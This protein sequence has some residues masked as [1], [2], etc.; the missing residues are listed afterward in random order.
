MRR[1]LAAPAVLHTLTCIAALS[2]SACNSAPFFYDDRC[3]PVSRDVSAAQS[4]PNAAGDSLGQVWITLVESRDPDIQRA[5]WYVSGEFLRGHLESARLVATGDTTL[6]LPL[7]GSP[8]GP[9]L[10]ITGQLDPYTGPVDFNQLFNR[11]THGGLTIVL[12]TSIPDR[13]VV[14]LPLVQ[15]VQ[16][17]DWGRA[18]C[19]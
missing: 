19:S 15:V 3:G 9:D 4:I 10:I 18:P 14:T 6:L 8:S 5:Y 12:A 2:L 13:R 17:N 7:P 16:F 11:A 1:T